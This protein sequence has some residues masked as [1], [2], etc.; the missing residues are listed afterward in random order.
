MLI[1]GSCAILC[2][3]SCQSL[4]A[5]ALSKCRGV[6][7]GCFKGV[8]CLYADSVG[9][10]GVDALIFYTLGAVMKKKIIIFALVII[11][12]TLAVGLTSCNKEQELKIEKITIEY[13]RQV[14][15]KKGDTF[16]TSDFTVTAYLS[17]ESTKEIVN[18]LIWHTDDLKLGEDNELTLAGEFE[19]KVD[20]LKYKDIT[21]KVTVSE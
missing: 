14:A 15:Y 19:L 6:P 16:S 3:E 2:C 10:A 12:A 17:D 21:I 7:Q 4:T 5:A 9:Y 8:T 20:F 11:V 1:L 18:N 13:N